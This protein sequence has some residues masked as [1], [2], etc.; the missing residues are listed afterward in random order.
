[1]LVNLSLNALDVMPSGGEIKIQLRTEAD[2]GLE[3]DMCDTGPGIDPL[4][5]DRLFT[6]FVSNKPTG[7]GLGLSIS[8][9]IVQNHGGTLTAF[10]QPEGGACFRIHLPKAFAGALKHADTSSR[11]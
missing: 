2:G 3:L 1:L 6:P 10:N 5:I 8:R 11:R 7:T 4:V 9:Q